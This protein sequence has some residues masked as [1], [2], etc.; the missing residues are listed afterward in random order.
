[1][2][3]EFCPRLVGLHASDDTCTCTGAVRL[4]LAVFEAPLSVAVTVAV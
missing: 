1:M 4:M 3:E 2:L